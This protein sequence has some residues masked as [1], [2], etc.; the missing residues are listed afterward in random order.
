MK[1]RLNPESTQRDLFRASFD[2]ILNPD[3]P[4]IV[5]AS[6]MDWQRFERTMAA[7]Y[8][9]DLGAPAKAARL[10]VGLVYLKHAFDESDESLLERWVENPYWQCFCGFTTMQHDPPIHPT[11]LVK[12]R[13][14]VGAERLAE[15]ITETID[16]A[17][18]E[19]Q[20]KPSELEHV[21]VDTTVGEKNITYP[22]DSKLL[23]KAILK[24][25]TLAKHR[26]ICLRQS[27]ARV[28]KRMAQKAGRYAHARQFKRMQRS[29]RKL[30]TWLGR[31]I[32]D[33][34]RKQSGPDVSLESLLAL[35]E[36]LHGQQQ[37]D[38]NKLYS[39][40]EPEV[41]CISKGKARVRYEF[42]QKIAVATTNRQ[43]WIVGVRVC[44]GNPYDGHTLAATLDTVRS[45][46]GRCVN[47]A[48][49]DKGY[50]GHGY[51]GPAQIHIAGTSERRLTR[52][53]RKRRRRRSAVEPKIGHLKSDNRLS[54]CFLRGL[55]GD[56]INAVL[57]AAGSN[58]QKLLKGLV[59]ALKT[60]LASWL[61]LP[62]QHV[63]RWATQFPTRF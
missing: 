45:T 8:S 51:E 40:H 3:H 12:W 44:E 29:L 11:S 35:C 28:A 39:L 14:R 56:A 23:L 6:K 46:T 10:M 43:N 48:Y 16:V 62:N 18:R 38:K 27:Y 5:L 34:R 15:L 19:K 63:L 58:L 41:V 54:R 22:T 24:L 13:Q 60:W 61:P 21:N 20:V 4:L 50:R 7:C 59:F 30:R 31:L 36:R 37:F 47:H 26:G 32:R 17:L 55:K 49:V 33:I 57:A 1:P 53:M 52:T 42:G 25:G 9:P 2:Q